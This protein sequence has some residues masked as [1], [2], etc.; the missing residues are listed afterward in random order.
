MDEGWW[1]RGE[2]CEEDGLPFCSR[3]RPRDLPDRLYMTEGSG[4]ATF[5]TSPTC[6][7]LVEGENAVE[8]RGGTK[9]PII[10]IDRKRAAST[11]KLPCLRCF[12]HLRGRLNG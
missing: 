8:R 12:P 10:V 6:Q 4:S 2:P 5:H 9:A 11:G 3:C 1:D 7:A